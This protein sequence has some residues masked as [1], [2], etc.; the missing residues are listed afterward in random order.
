MSQKLNYNALGSRPAFP[1]SIT[2]LPK[3]DWLP[4]SLES[5]VVNAQNLVTVDFE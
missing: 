5:Y 3:N 4:T 2:E 1:T